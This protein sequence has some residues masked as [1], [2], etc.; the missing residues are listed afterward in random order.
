MPGSNGQVPEESQNS[1]LK[2]PLLADVIRLPTPQAGESARKFRVRFAYWRMR[3]TGV[4]QSDEAGRRRRAA[5]P[6]QLTLQLGE[7]AV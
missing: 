2:R 5:R 4:A 6:E 7:E 3:R 1:N